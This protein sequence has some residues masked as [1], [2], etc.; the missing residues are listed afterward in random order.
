MSA[1]K[2]LVIYHSNCNDGFTAAWVFH[3]RFGNNIEFFA[4]SYNN[5]LPEIAVDRPCVYL[6]DFS[7]KPDDMLKLIELN[8]GVVLI[9]HHKTALD[10]LPEIVRQTTLDKFSAFCD[11][12]RSGATLAWDY[13]FPDE[14]RPPFLDNVEDRDLWRFKLGDTKTF[15]AYSQSMEKTFENWDKMMYA[16]ELEKVKLL[17]EGSGI[18]RKYAK[19]VAELSK[20]FRLLDIFGFKNIPVVNCPGMFA[21]DVGSQ[22]CEDNPEAAFSLTYSH[23]TNKVFFSLR[24]RGATGEDV[25]VLAKLVGGGGHR[26]AAG[27]SL[28]YGETANKL[29][30]V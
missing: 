24:S 3:R 29:T 10:K 25:S 12:D 7:Y 20:H 4:A 1:S 5:P 15:H 8:A 2:P 23:G 9:D 16:T 22:L 13:L 26:N 21:S 27:F 6:V 30:G 19:D 11:I 18:M 17:N 28:P 14:P